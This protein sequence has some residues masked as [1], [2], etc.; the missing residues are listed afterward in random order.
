M[1]DFACSKLAHLK[2]FIF[3]TCILETLHIQKYWF[4]PWR[5]F[6]ALCIAG[7]LQ[8]RALQEPNLFANCMFGDYQAE[9]FDWMHFVPWNSYGLFLGPSLKWIIL[10]CLD[11]F[12]NPGY[13]WSLATMNEPSMWTGWIGLDLRVGWG[14]ESAAHILKLRKLLAIHNLF[15]YCP[16]QPQP[17]CWRLSI[18]EKNR[19]LPKRNSSNQFY[20]D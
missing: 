9:S 6:S 14:R 7:Y 8:L 3:K 16:P 11:L 18:E 2:L 5:I 19:C 20:P 4:L 10:L 13:I 15:V 12:A 1:V 17:Q